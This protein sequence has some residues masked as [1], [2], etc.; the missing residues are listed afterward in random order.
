MSPVRHL[1]AVRTAIVH[2]NQK[3]MK[4]DGWSQGQ[5]VVHAWQVA[6][7]MLEVL[8]LK[9]LGYSGK[10]DNRLTRTTEQLPHSN[11]G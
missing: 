6:L 10:Y 8:L 2:S 1:V 3:R 11:P 4:D 9:K 5:H 7:W